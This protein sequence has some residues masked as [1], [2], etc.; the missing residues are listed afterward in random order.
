MFKLIM[1]Q[2]EL[3]SF[4][5]FFFGCLLINEIQDFLYLKS[6]KHIQEFFEQGRGKKRRKNFV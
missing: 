6:Q 5:F 2:K 4:I 3:S 1:E